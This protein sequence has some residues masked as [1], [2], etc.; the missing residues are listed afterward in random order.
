MAKPESRGQLINFGLRK[1]GY[2]VLEINL[3][4]DQIHDALDDTIQLYNERH[5]NGIERMYL[6]YKITQDDIDR[7]SAKDTNGVGIVTTTGIST[8]S[9][10][11][12]AY[13]CAQVFRQSER[14]GRSEQP[15]C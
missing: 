4:T 3:D 2:P 6:K 9:S 14:R 12:C 11:C 13:I 15:R 8:W 1:L 10:L 7:G 5:Y